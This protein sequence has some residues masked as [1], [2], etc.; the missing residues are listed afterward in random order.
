[1][2]LYE[3]R[4]K[5]CGHQ[6][7]K[8]QGFS[9]PDEK[10]CYVCHGELERLISAPAVQFKGSG[11]YSTDYPSKSSKQSSAG[12]GEGGDAKSSDKATSPEKGG[13][14]D[15]GGASDKGA[16]PASSTSSG[17]SGGAAPSKAPSTPPAK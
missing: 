11:F 6:F 5:S 10:E 3:Y 1:L 9:A 4:C 13:S 2:P 7:E 16:S 17:D 14:S 12:S 8:L 15:K